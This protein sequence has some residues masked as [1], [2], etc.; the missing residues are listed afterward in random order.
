MCLFLLSTLIPLGLVG[1]FSVKTAEDLIAK[2]VSS[3]LENVID[4]KVA[5]LERW[6]VERKADILVVAGSSILRSM[7]PDLIKGSIPF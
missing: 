7:D 6:L 5:I 2:M 3:Q 1:G 4:D